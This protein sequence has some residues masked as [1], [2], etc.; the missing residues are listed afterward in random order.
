MQQSVMSITKST[1]CMRST[2]HFPMKAIPTRF[3]PHVNTILMPCAQVSL[4]ENYLRV[5]VRS[6]NEKKVIQKAAK[7]AIKGR[8]NMLSYDRDEDRRGRESKHMFGYRCFV[9]LYVCL[10][11]IQEIK[12]IYSQDITPMPCLHPVHC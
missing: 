5:S 4:K 7:H 12:D 10:Y 1:Q 6:S 2:N 3:I 9:K 8:K 11:V